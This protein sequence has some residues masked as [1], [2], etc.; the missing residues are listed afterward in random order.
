VQGGPGTRRP[1][2]FLPETC[3]APHGLDEIQPVSTKKK[4]KNQI[5][6][7]WIG[8]VLRVGQVF[9]HPYEWVMPKWV[10]ELLACW[11]AMFL[12]LFGM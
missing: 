9:A 12:I 11:K 4:K 6:A 10:V 8:S 3:L 1:K 7:D 5:R 2:L